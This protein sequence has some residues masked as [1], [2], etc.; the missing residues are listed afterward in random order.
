MPAR[1]DRA[2]G[3]SD[4]SG[5]DADYNCRRSVFQYNYS[6]DN[7]QGAFLL[8]ALGSP[9]SRGFNEG[10]VV[11]YNISQ[12]DSGNL[13]RISGVVKDALIHNNTFYARP[14]L[15]NPRDSGA[16]PRIIYHKTWQGWSDGVRWVN[17]IFYN[18]SPAA[19]YE[20]GESGCNRK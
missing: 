17:N 6:H 19:I 12:N 15:A 14:D 3:D 20:F 13:V 16:A 18:E 9:R 10:V 5:F 11:R 7:E 1:D 8:C 2:P 4:A